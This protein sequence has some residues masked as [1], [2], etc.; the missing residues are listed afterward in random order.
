MVS[1]TIAAV[2]DQVI[3]GTPVTREQADFLAATELAALEELFKGASRIRERFKG[4]RVRCCSI[5]ASKVGR[6]GE[7]CAFCSQSGHFNTHVSGLTVLEPDQVLEAAREAARNGAESFGIVNS[8]YGPS[9]AEIEHWGEVVQRVRELGSM[10]ACASLGVVN[11]EQARRLAEFGVQRYNHNL[12]TSRRHFPN[13]IK[14][15]SYDDRLDALRNLK[16]A[17]ISVCSGG[18]FGMGETWQ[19]RLD[20]AFELRDLGVEVVPL[21]FLIPIDGT[22][23]EGTDT[24]PAMECLKII[25]VFRF[26]LSQQEIKICGGRER[27]I[28]ELQDRIFEAGADSFLIG[29]YLTTC[30]RAAAEDRRVVAEQGLELTGFDQAATPPPARTLEAPSKSGNSVRLTVLPA[31]R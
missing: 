1:K 11:P 17:G 28:G 15:H 13:I 19:D 16:Q 9:D 31:T 23:L 30:G 20:L 10:R 24:L 5:V 8:G 21:N 4:K 12:Q 26:I 27:C 29:N 14:T 25:A 2:A 22:P 6:C 7:D 18:L 3:A